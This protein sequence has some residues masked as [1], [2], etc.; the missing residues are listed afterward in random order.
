MAASKSNDSFFGNDFSKGFSAMP[1]DMQGMM[2]LSR[3]N[4]Q[5][6]GEAQQLAMEGIQAIAQK[7]TEFL[8]Q[9]VEDN[10]KLAKE[11]MAEGSTE[12]KVAKQADMVKKSYEKSMIN[13]QKI[14]E[15]VSNSNQK[16]SEII[17]KRISC[18]LGEMKDSLEKTKK[19]TK[20]A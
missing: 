19:S 8:S 20:A 5:A 4:F 10:S 11:M 3:K 14:A 13:A 7:Q 16:A 1:F 18:S 6:F 2:E 12:E 17:S 9:M 15:M